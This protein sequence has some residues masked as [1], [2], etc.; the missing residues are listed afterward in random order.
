MLNLNEVV[1]ELK[2]TSLMDLWQATCSYK[3][4][5]GI[6]T[7]SLKADEFDLKPLRIL[8]TTGL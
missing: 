4:T 5:R 7:R 6:A 1:E 8:N 3:F 2:K